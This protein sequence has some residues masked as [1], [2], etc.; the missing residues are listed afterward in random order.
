MF[1]Y[2]P[3]VYELVS[4]SLFDVYAKPVVNIFNILGCNQEVYEDNLG[5]EKEGMTFGAS[6][7]KEKLEIIIR[8]AAFSRCHTY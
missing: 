4:F 1:H 6:R 8:Y 2:R 3:C 7:F 5:S